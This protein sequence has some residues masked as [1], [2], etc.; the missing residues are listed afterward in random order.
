MSAP[1]DA[2]DR[3]RFLRLCAGAFA[4]TLAARKADAAELPRVTPD[5]P[6]AK[7][8]GYVEDASTLDAREFPLHQ[9]SQACANCQQ[10]TKQPGSAYGPCLIFSGKAVSE[11]GW[12]SAYVPK[13]KA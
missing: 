8:L 2:T 12:C 3:R 1:P 9:P 4:V 5:D 6:T 7:A 13:A 11:L 10:F